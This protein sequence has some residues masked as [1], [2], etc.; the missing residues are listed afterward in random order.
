L[1]GHPKDGSQVAGYKLPAEELLAG[2]PKDASQV[3][4]YVANLFF[5]IT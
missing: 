1:A 3:A 2:H 5:M 4:G